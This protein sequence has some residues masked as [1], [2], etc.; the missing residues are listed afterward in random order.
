MN[1]TNCKIC[2]QDM[3]S[4]AIVQ[5]TCHHSFCKECLLNL[6]TQN[7][8]SK[9]ID[10]SIMKCPE[11]GCNVPINYYTLKANLPKELHEEYDTLKAEMAEVAKKNEEKKI[12]CPKCQIISMIWKGADYFTCPICHK[13]FCSNENCLGEWEKH[14]KRSC[15]QYQKKYNK[16]AEKFKMLQKEQG[17]CACPVCASIVE[18][19]GNCNTIR[20]Q[21]T[22]CQKKTLFCYLCGEKL[23]EA[24]AGK[25][26]PKG[27]FYKECVGKH[28]DAVLLDDERRENGYKENNQRINIRSNGENESLIKKC[29]EEKDRKFYNF[30]S[31]TGNETLCEKAKFLFLIILFVFL[32][33]VFKITCFIVNS[34]CFICCNNKYC[35]CFGVEKK[36][37]KCS[38]CQE[39]YPAEFC[40][41]CCWGFSVNKCL[42]CKNPEVSINF[43]DRNHNILSYFLKKGSLPKPDDPL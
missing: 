16:N 17:W 41:V 39:S 10:D 9:M 34:R 19:T 15:T 13:M 6:W 25:H 37:L 40:R 2:F 1:T 3:D 35:G 32:N 4:D 24:Q 22:K 27:E 7:I 23:D 43:G 21:S 14:N 33:S 8:Q 42:Y 36:T 20:C 30:G 12:S 31:H 29:P 26:F 38:K 18:K 28:H 11:D 5:L